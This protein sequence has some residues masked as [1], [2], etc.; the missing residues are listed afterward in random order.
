MQC[1]SECTFPELSKLEFWTNSSTTVSRQ[2]IEACISFV[3]RHPTIEE[4]VLLSYTGVQPFKSD[5]LP[6]LKRL[7]AY[8]PIIEAVILEMR[9]SFT[10]EYISGL[11]AS[12]RVLK[13]LDNLKVNR[14]SLKTL[15]VDGFDDLAS[16]V[17]LAEIFPCLET[18]YVP[19]YGAGAHTFG[20]VLHFFSLVDS[21]TDIL[22]G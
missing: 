14:D 22:A 10:L 15:T 12:D 18:L 11:C 1:L 2:T 6:M 9:H 7:T 19:Q 8:H 5:S 4:I 16:V 21:S 3:E 13:Y 17:K 20:T